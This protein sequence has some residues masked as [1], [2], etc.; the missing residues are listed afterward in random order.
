MTLRKADAGDLD[1]MMA[2]IR[3]AQASMRALG[4]DQWQNGYPDAAVS[5]ED[6]ARGERYLAAEEEGI[7]ACAYISF[8]GEPDYNHI[9]NGRWLTDGAYCVIHRIACDVRRRRTGAASFIIAQ[10]KEMCRRRGV[11][12]IR[13]DTHQDNAP[14]QA[15]LRKNGFVHC[16]TIFVQSGEKRLAF[17]AFEASAQD[18]AYRPENQDIAG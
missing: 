7:A 3:G 16:G 17:E 1:A 4:I 12:S 8:D 6:I 10:A 5:A 15:M 13:I 18:A 14:M 2:I 11:S 9:E